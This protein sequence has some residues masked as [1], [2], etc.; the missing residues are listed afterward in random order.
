LVVAV[1]IKTGW[2][3]CADKRA[4]NTLSG[5]R[6]DEIKIQ[7]IGGLIFGV[8]GKSR[9][10]RT[11]G[12]GIVPSFSALDSVSSYLKANVFDGTDPFIDELNIRVR[13]DFSRSVTDKAWTAT[14][15]SDGVVFQVPM[16]WTERGMPKYAVLRLIFEDP[17]FK[18]QPLETAIGPYPLAYGQRKVWEEIAQGHQPQFDA[19]RN[20]VLVRKFFIRPYVRNDHD[21]QDAELFARRMIG[22]TSENLPLLGEREDVSE[23]HDCLTTP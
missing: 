3:V 20:D 11:E 16:F 4:I 2:V 19:L 15:D 7:K 10:Y 9:F 17:V 22:F 8:T 21:S 1:P 5:F 13:D 23:T 14:L 12:N 6:D 18:L